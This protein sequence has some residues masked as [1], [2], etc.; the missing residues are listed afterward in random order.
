MEETGLYT[1]VA[2]WRNTMSNVH[3][4]TLLEEELH[5]GGGEEVKGGGVV[6]HPKMGISLNW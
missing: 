1:L 4:L 5:Q 3:L 2:V 6:R